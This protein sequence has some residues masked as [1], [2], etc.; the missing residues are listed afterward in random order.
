MSKPLLM[1]YV[2]EVSFLVQV[3]KLLN[4]EKLN[5]Q[6]AA[7]NMFKLFVGNCHKSEEIKLV[8][9]NN[10]QV[11]TDF[12]TKFKL[13]DD[14]NYETDQKYLLEQLS[15]LGEGTE[16]AKWKRED[17]GKKEDSVENANKK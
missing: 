3:M 17:V 4:T 6:T 1:R 12:L 11:L 8:L 7:Y 15:E 14:A 9:R 13:E 10:K 16:E 2:N 5:L